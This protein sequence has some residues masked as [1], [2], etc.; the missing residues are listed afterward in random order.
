[1]NKF[2]VINKLGYIGKYSNRLH[3]IINHYYFLLIEIKNILEFTNIDKN[4]FPFI[5]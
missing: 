5:F 1:M 2:K 4:Y 3:I